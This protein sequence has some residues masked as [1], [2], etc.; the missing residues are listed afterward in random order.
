MPHW[1]SVRCSHAQNDSSADILETGDQEES[2]VLRIGDIRLVF[3]KH[4]RYVPA[5]PFHHFVTDVLYKK[6]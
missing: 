6:C 4:R 2:R 3:V 1:L 5:L